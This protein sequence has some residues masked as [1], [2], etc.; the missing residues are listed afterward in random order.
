MAEISRSVSSGTVREENTTAGN[1]NYKY[2]LIKI[3][4][5]AEIETDEGVSNRTVRENSTERK[6]FSFCVALE[7]TTKEC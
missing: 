4:K 2:E 1:F 5:R 3:R 7:V 6:S